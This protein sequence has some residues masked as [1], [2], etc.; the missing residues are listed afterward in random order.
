MSACSWNHNNY[1]NWRH[2]KYWVF[3]P[4]WHTS[5]LTE[6]IYDLNIGSFYAEM[7]QSGEDSIF[8]HWGGLNVGPSLRFQRI[9]FDSQRN[10]SSDQSKLKLLN[11]CVW[12]ILRSSVHLHTCASALCTCRHLYLVALSTTGKIKPHW[13][14][15][16]YGHTLY[17][18]TCTLCHS[19]IQ[20]T[21]TEGVIIF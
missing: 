16:I 15:F 21:L 11:L 20:P 7:A 13:R 8:A 9:H 12:P 3:T 10:H 18:N 6:L 1:L 19:P 4:V 17:N 5:C 14:R 2:C